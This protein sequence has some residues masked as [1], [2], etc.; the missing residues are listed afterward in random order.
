LSWT[1]ATE[2]G[3]TISTYLVERCAGA[4]CTS[5]AQIGTSATTSFN[6]TGLTGSTSYSYRVR[7]KDTAGNMGPYSATATAT[8]AAPVIT[9]PTNLVATAASGTQINLSWTAA[10]ETGGTIS[11]YLVERCQGAGCTSFAQVG[12][13]S[14]TTFGDTGLTASTTYS[15][16]VRVKDAAGNMGPYSAT[17]SATTTA[18]GPPP[19]ITFVQVNSAVPASG[20]SV[21]VTYT[22]AQVVGDLNVVIV[23]WND[24]TATVKSIA[25][26]KG[27]P[28]VLASGPIQVSG[29][30][31]QSI[32]YAKNIVAAAASA[33]KVTVTFSTS[34][35]YPDV[36]I[37][38]YS[39]I[40]TVNPFDGGAGATGTATTTDSGALTT[41]YANDLLIGAN[42]VSTSTAAPGTGFTQRVETNPDGDITEDRVVTATGSYHATATLSAAGPWIIQIVAFRAAGAP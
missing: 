3:G 26:T 36:R 16:R 34:A 23:G 19:P 37:L 18:A 32:Y 9:A 1:A 33:N 21:A 10:T 13:S 4:A 15:Y 2:T 24:T 31:T 7:V 28:Y 39:G 25:D 17:A 29:T 14:T 20:A 27:N 22:K 11:S 30:L 8:T 38:E 35:I 5:F 12:T 41:A 6:D 40:D 42:I